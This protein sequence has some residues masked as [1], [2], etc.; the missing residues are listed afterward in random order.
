M[1]FQE[2]L[3]PAV[4]TQAEAPDFAGRGRRAGE[5]LA[6]GGGRRKIRRGR[7]YRDG[8]LRQRSGTAAPVA[9]QVSKRPLE[10]HACVPITDVLVEVEI[11]ERRDDEHLGGEV[12]EEPRHARHQLRQLEAGEGAGNADAPAKL[13]ELNA[14]LALMPSGRAGQAL[15]EARVKGVRAV[16]DQNVFVRLDQ[17]RQKIMAQPRR[18]PQAVIERQAALRQ[19]PGLRQPAGRLPRLRRKRSRLPTGIGGRPQRDGLCRR[20]LPR[21]SSGNSFAGSHRA[22]GLSPYS[23]WPTAT[24]GP[25]HPSP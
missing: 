12:R 8:K 9:L 24:P 14:A 16:E 4:F 1:L 15:E 19:P 13:A 5:K 21:F 7:K 6:A 18:F 22:M 2:Q 20:S 25:V 17:P 10:R 3:R 23:R 11:R